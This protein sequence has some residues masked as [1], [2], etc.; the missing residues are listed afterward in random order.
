M[1]TVWPES[2]LDL[3][4]HMRHR[5]EV[6]QWLL[7]EGYQYKPTDFQDP[8]FEVEIAQCVN[9]NPNGIYSMPGV[10]AIVTFIKPLPRAERTRDPVLTEEGPEPEDDGPHELKVQVI[11][12]K[13]TPMEVILG[14]H[15]SKSPCPRYLHCS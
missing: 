9:R 2:D 14:F 13:N 11:V 3:Y 7:D 10:M 6:A 15:S 4:V 5:R 12:A 1:R 8:R